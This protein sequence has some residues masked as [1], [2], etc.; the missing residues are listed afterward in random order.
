MASIIKRKSKYSVVYYYNDENGEKKQRWETFYSHKEALKRKS[1]VEG[2]IINNVYLPPTN[3]TVRDFLYDFVTLYGESKWGV[4]TY[5]MNVGLIGNYINPAIG[6]VPIQDITPKFVDQFYKRLQT[7]KPVVKPTHRAKTEYLTPANIEKIHKLLRCAFKQAV[8]W[9]M[10]S[11][12]PFEYANVE[13]VK[14]KPRD[15]WDEETI[16]KA[17]DACT[18]SKLYIAMNFA[19]ACSMRVGEILGLTWDHVHISEE[20]EA[21]NN[22]RIE[23]VQ[24]LARASMNAMQAIG[25]KDI[26]FVFPNIM[27]NPGS[28]LVLKK[29][30]TDSSIRTVWLP[31]TL[32][33]ILRE[34]KKAQAEMQEF[35]GSDYKHYNMVISLPDG[36]PCE[37]RVMHKEF[38]RLKKEAGLPN[39]VFHSLRHSSATYKLKLSQG[40]MKAIQG[41][42]G[43]AQ[44]DMV[45]KIYAHIV[46]NDRK[47][48]A[49]KFES[50]FYSNPDLRGVRPP[51]AKDQT[52]QLDVLSLAE[53]LA[54]SPELLDQLSMLLSQKT[55]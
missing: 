39:V 21:E 47:V 55:G 17:L 31:K 51:T 40:D 52:V 34:W 43:W 27:P 8:K 35:L 9:E 19:F 50:S 28:R 32:V 5:D 38:A 53:Q 11:R 33:Y 37:N 44:M 46:D 2:Q 15:I 22:T 49:Q 42:G 10:M 18:D 12:N 6:D 29:P 26:Y 7:T 16:S 23:I 30:K 54:K 24:E 3:Q 41:D 36:R 13:K 14:Y 1:E 4:S 25:E 45:A 20:D 48:N